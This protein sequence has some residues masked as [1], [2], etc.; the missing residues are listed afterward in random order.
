[1]GKDLYTN[2][3]LKA[4]A[5]N[6]IR[7]ELVSMDVGAAKDQRQMQSDA[8]EAQ[9]AAITS[10][11][12]ALATVGAT[13]GSAM[14]PYKAGKEN[15]NAELLLAKLDSTQIKGD[16]IL[17]DVANADGTILKNQAIT[18][19]KG[20]PTYASVSHG[21][22]LE[23][24]KNLPVDVGGGEMV[25]YKNLSRKQRKAYLAKIGVE[26]TKFTEYGIFSSNPTVLPKNS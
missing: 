17:G 12:N 20:D 21:Q 8:Q 5:Q 26:E 6:A 10:G 9:A 14:G 11:I 3:K 13:V 16:Q 23:A 7:D 2:A 15:K 1:M 18:D 19:S 25:L 24:I 4:E 22:Q